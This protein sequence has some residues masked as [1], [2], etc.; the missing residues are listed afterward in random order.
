VLEPGLSPSSKYTIV[1]RTK[2]GEVK[3]KGVNHLAVATGKIDETI[4]FW[5]DLLGMR[6]VAGM[7]EP[8]NRQYFFEISAYCS[9]AF[10]EWPGVEPVPEKEH[11]RVVGGPFAFDHV[12]FGL[13]N[14]DELY[15]LKDK[16]NAA[17][18]W[19]SEV[20]DHGFIHSIFSFDPNGI[21]IE[22]A[23]NVEGVDIG[24]NPVMNDPPPTEVAGEGPEPQEGKWPPVEKP[25]LEKDRRIYPGQVCR[26]LRKT[27]KF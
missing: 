11:G 23:W 2:E 8:G 20:I 4:R 21:P 18:I 6:L 16:L 14:E 15:E 13:E 27:R 7:G 22:F 26:F 17:D 1:M 12:A 5:R 10:F 9:I 25:T 24:K 19:V 3:F